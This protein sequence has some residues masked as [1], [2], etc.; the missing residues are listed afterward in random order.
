MIIDDIY[1]VFGRDIGKKDLVY[2][3]KVYKSIMFTFRFVYGVMEELSD[4]DSL[5]NDDD[6]LFE[7]LDDEEL[8]DEDG[9]TLD[10]NGK[11]IARILKKRLAS[12]Q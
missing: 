9:T 10:E 2:V 4:L 12:I 1:D 8:G 11:P 7:E 3:T 6:L 5:E